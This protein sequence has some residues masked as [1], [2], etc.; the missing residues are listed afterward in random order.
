MLPLWWPRFRCVYCGR[1]IPTGNRSGWWA[2]E[3]R[4]RD[5]LW[6]ACDRHADLVPRD[7]LL[8]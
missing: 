6:L 4:V 2:R 7:P 5:S 3:H 1:R 8:A